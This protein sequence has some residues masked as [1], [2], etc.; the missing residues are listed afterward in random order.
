MSLLHFLSFR[1]NKSQFLE[2]SRAA[3]Q[4]LQVNIYFAVA[5]HCFVS[6]E[7]GSAGKNKILKYFQQIFRIEVLFA[8]N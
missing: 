6:Q 2:E 8:S 1:W 3:L 4:V 7:L 5:L